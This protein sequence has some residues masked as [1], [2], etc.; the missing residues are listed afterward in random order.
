MRPP[1]P[2]PHPQVLPGY[3]RP[4]RRSV[5]GLIAGLAGL[6]AAGVALGGS[7]ATV[8]EVNSGSTH[9]AV[10]WWGVEQDGPIGDTSALI[11]LSIVLATLL[12]VSGSVFAFTRTVSVARLLLAL[13]LGTLTGAVVSQSMSTLQDMAIWDKVPLDPG[14]RMEFTAGPGLFLPIGAVVIG[15]VAVAFAWRIPAGR[16]EPNTPPMGMRLPYGPPTGMPPGA[17]RPGA[18]MP[19]MPGPGAMPGPI[20]PPGM[21]VGVTPPTGTPMGAPVPAVDTADADITQRTKVTEDPPVSP[22]SAAPPVSPVSPSDPTEIPPPAPAGA[23]A[24]AA[25]AESDEWAAADA[26]P[27]PAEPAID[28]DALATLAGPPTTPEPAE[29]EAATEVT[30]PAEPGASAA[31]TAEEPAA[32]EADAPATSAAESDAPTEAG[33]STTDE[34]PA[35]DNEPTEDTGPKPGTSSLGGLPAAPPAP[36]LSNEQGK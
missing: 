25:Q 13:G 23:A 27:A 14:E 24:A 5:A 17:P 20:V 21:H 10:H 1:F 33:D 8:H 31:E 29:P 4:P 32:A 6:V 30:P 15:I 26:E 16:V 18:P 35:A 34:A 22:V 19:G 12:L 9:F 2:P 36:E 28:A 11:G 3:V 7:F